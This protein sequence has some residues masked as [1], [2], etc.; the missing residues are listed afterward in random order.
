MIFTQSMTCLDETPL[1]VCY[2]SKSLVFLKQIIIII[3]IIAIII[4]M[5]L[6]LTLYK[7]RIS[8]A[9]ACRVLA[10]LCRRNNRVENLAARLHLLC[11]KTKTCLLKDYERNRIDILVGMDIQQDCTRGRN[12]GYLHTTSY[13][14]CGLLSPF[15]PRELKPQILFLVMIND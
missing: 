7:Q 10:E 5:R 13:L 8:F 11:P 14:N 6:T 2:H 1:C 15:N 4:I 3:I 12:N 9:A